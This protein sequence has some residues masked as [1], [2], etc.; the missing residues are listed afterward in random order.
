MSVDM[1]S[2]KLSQLIDPDFEIEQ[3]VY[4]CWFT[5]GP[6]WNPDGQF[7]L[8]SDVPAS[9]RRRWDERNGV[10]RVVA[11]P[12]NRGNGQ[13]ID[14]DGNLIVCEHET[15]TVVRMKPDGSGEG[16]EV[17]A[18]HYQGKE[19]NSPND[20]VVRSD[21]S[22]YFSDP[23]PGRTDEDHGF[24]RPI[25]LDFKGLFRLPPGGG[26][27]ELLAD[28]F[29][30][31]NGLCFSPDESLLYID[32]SSRGHIRVFDVHS[33]GSLSGD[34]VFAENIRHPGPWD[35]V[36]SPKKGG[37]VDGM[38]CD[39]EGNIWVTGPGGLWVFSPDGEHLGAVHTPQSVGNLHWGGED[40][41]WIFV[42]ANTGVYRFRT[43]TSGHLEPFMR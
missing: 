4:G 32:D 25:Q 33:D 16:R 29:D 1:R 26:E 15:S 20:I 10:Q 41:S 38:K 21:G 36:L 8:F 24:P 23:T 39:A 30:A 37:Y 14:L 34:R 17:I 12:T 27:L 6:I 3:I 19:L 11:R 43:R 9:T 2:Q 35:P 28:D 13:T 18:S 31:P 42:C 40:W 22:I 7:L 5:E